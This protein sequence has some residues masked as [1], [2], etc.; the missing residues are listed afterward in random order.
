MASSRRG[1]CRTG[2]GSASSR[3]CPLV[4]ETYVKVNG[5]WRYAYRTVDQHGQVIDVLVSTRRDTAA[6]RQ[7][8]HRA[9]TTLKVTPGEVVTDTAPTYVREWGRPAP[10]GAAPHRTACQQS[11]R[12]RPQPA[13]APAQTDARTTHRPHR[14]YD[15]HRPR[16]RAEPPTRTPRT[17]HRRP[18]RDPGR[19]RIHRTCPSDPTITADTARRA[20]RSANA[21]APK[22]LSSVRRPVWLRLRTWQGSWHGMPN[23]NGFGDR[24]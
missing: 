10:V 3:C 22:N 24:R 18:T 9:L 14:P 8:L 1:S 5:V 7:F 13:Q 15:H 17:R 20:H 19:Y 12:G 4:D 2:C 16:L 21:T 6:A 23:R 11:D